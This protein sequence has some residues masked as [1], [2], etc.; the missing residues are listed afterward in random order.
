MRQR[1]VK[2][3]ALVIAVIASFY[4][5]TFAWQKLRPTNISSAP[6]VTQIVNDLTVNLVNREGGLRQGDNEVVIEFRDRNGQLIDVGSVS[7]HISMN[8]PGMQM[9]GGGV[10]ERT[11]TPGQYRA[12]VKAEMA[13]DWNARISYDSLRGKGQ[14]NFSLNVKQ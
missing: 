3:V 6:F 14:T 7:F 5:G 1:L 9:Q 8:M 12:K 4:I 11:A 2:W 13:G 10:A